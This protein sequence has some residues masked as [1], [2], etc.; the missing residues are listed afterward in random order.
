MEEEKQLQSLVP[1]QA[2]ESLEAKCF[3][4]AFSKVDETFKKLIDNIVKNIQVLQ[5]QPSA[6]QPLHRHNKELCTMIFTKKKI[7]PE[8]LIMPPPKF[9]DAVICKVSATLDAFEARRKGKLQ[10]KGDQNLQKQP[11]Q[12][13][14]GNVAKQ[15]PR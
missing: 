9:R 14:A 2:A 11:S 12:S 7:N 8:K 13:K 4:I 6:A 10:N 1:Q 3:S 5:C 15:P